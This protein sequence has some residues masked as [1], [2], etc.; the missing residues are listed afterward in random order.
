M[1]SWLKSKEKVDEFY[2]LRQLLDIHIKAGRRCAYDL[3][4]ASGCIPYKENDM[5]GQ[6]FW[7][8]RSKYWISV[9]NPGNDGKNY[10]SMLHN[11]MDKLERRIEELEEF[12]KEK[13]LEVPVWF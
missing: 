6:E 8:E 3:D 7:H 1:L 2:E 5:F 9:F 11:Q 4:H 10:Q 12:I 13:G